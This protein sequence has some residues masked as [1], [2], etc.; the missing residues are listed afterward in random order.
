MQLSAFFIAVVASTI[1]FTSALPTPGDRVTTPVAVINSDIPGSGHVATALQALVGPD[2]LASK[3]NSRAQGRKPLPKS[4]LGRPP[5]TRSSS[6]S[7]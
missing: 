7:D 4:R 6:D 2:Q 5:R 1:G 3:E